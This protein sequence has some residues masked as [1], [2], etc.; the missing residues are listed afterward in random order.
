MA[1]Y[2]SC[3]T[4]ILVWISTTNCR[5]CV[6]VWR[7]LWL[8]AREAPSAGERSHLDK[9]T[10]IIFGLYDM[11]YQGRLVPITIFTGHY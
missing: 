8:I 9:W 5:S 11:C 2:G 7:L 10:V 1:R 6:Y 4:S 3:H